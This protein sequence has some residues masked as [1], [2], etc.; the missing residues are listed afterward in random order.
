MPRLPPAHAH[1]CAACHSLCC[2]APL[3][4][5]RRGFAFDKALYAPCPHLDVGRARCRVHD[6][7]ARIGNHGCLDYTCHGAG[8]LVTAHALA[9][10]VDW[11]VLAADH[12]ARREVLER[13]LE[14]HALLSAL[15]ELRAAD[16]ILAAAIDA[17]VAALSL[18]ELLGSALDLAF[19]VRTAG[20]VEE[21][22]VG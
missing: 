14:L 1:D 18:D 7:L 19:E 2:V 16:Q 21:E 17:R 10:G 13:F 22:D 5:V 8:P 20:W 6:R 11:R 3:I 9:R 4:T 15:A 12:P